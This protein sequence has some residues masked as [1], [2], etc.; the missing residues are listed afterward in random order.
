[1][2]SPL[3]QSIARVVLPPALLMALYLLFRGHNAPGGGF[4]AGLLTAAA[5]VLQFVAGGRAS[6]A[7][8]VPFRAERLIVMGLALALLTGVGAQALGAPFLTS[9][10]G[11]VDLPVLG[12]LE[13]STAFCFDLGVYLVVTGVT[14][15]VLLTIE[16]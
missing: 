16:E 1:M 12:H 3:L 13:S 8:V 15:H 4:I 11:A 2:I 6:V 14:V 9:T 5:F 7:R 10:F